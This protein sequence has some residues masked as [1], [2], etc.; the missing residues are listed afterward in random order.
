MKNI[1]RAKNIGMKT[2]LIT[3]KS[4]DGRILPEDKPEVNDP[5][6]DISMETIDDFFNVLPGLLESE[7]VFD[8][9]K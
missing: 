1:R 3:G 9:R 2:V 4:E 7:P 5:S 8:P 6:V